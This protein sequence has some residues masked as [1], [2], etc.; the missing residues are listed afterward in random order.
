M[1]GLVVQRGE[2]PVIQDQDLDSVERLEAA[3]GAAVTMG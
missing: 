3:A 1:T 2:P